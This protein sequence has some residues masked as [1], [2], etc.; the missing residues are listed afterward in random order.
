MLEHHRGSEC[1]NSLCSIAE[2]STPYCI[3][4][5][6]EERGI[7][8]IISRGNKPYPIPPA[9]PQHYHLRQF[10]NSTPS[11][12]FTAGR[13]IQDL[14]RGVYTRRGKSRANALQKPIFFGW[15]G[16]EPPREDWRELR[17]R[18]AKR[19]LVSRLLKRLCEA[20]LCGS[21][22]FPIGR[23]IHPDE[24]TCP[25][26]HELPSFPAS[27]F[28]LNSDDESSGRFLR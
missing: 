2:G 18:G 9:G 24:H 28:I 17:R 11:L 13:G 20:V 26:V 3:V 5:R 7:F 23:F 1:K 10:T 22:R 4:G 21:H 14:L 16:Y 15:R 6:S 8:E 12:S 25:A 19:L 27:R